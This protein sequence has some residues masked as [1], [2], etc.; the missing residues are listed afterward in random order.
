MSLLEQ[1][2]KIREQTLAEDHP[3]RLASQQALATMF[4]DLG[5]RNAS[6]QI[7]KHVVEIQRQ[8]LDKHHPDR[9]NSEAWLEYFEDEMCNVEAA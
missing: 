8:V 2:V 3:S 1:V 9:K 6:L 4:W 5:R 7:M